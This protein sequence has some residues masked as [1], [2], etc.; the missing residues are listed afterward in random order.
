MGTAATLWR[1]LLLRGPQPPSARPS[2]SCPL[3]AVHG[4]HA[5]VRACRGVCRL[6]VAVL[7]AVQCSW[8]SMAWRR[9]WQLTAGKRDLHQQ[10]ARDPQLSQL[11]QL[12]KPAEIHRG[13]SMGFMQVALSAPLCHQFVKTVGWSNECRVAGSVYRVT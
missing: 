5:C 7:G 9:A 12:P 6:C 13:G 11:V 4:P 1:Y 3:V 8:D 2:P 10:L